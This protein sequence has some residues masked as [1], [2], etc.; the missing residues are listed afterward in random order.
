MVSVTHCAAARS[1]R[2]LLHFGTDQM[3]VFDSFVLSKQ[4]LFLTNFQLQPIVHVFISDVA[5]R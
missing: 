2:K 3:A 5:F 4:N 1:H